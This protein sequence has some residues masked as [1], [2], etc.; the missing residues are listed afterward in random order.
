MN[1]IEKL[2]DAFFNLGE[3]LTNLFT[4]L[5]NFLV[6]P[7]ALLLQFFEGIFYFINVVFQILVLLVRIF[8]AL[9]Q[10]FFGLVASLFMTISNMVGFA[11]TGELNLNQ[12]TRLGFDTAL[13][14][15][16][17]TGL[18]TVV[19]NVLIAILWIYFAY[20]IIGMFQESSSEIA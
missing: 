11:P 6:K 3:H 9:F 19:P 17:G 7:L 16:G 20:K 8:V 18:L 5:V 4:S 2:L 14:Q 10:F 13:S 12:A 1:F 15:V